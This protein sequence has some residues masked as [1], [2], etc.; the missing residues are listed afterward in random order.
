M[1]G[2]EAKAVTDGAVISLTITGIMGWLTPIV[3]FVSSILGIIWM[4]IR[5]YETKTVQKILF[6]EDNAFNQ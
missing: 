5:I 6:G 2:T 1:N 3:A 4:C